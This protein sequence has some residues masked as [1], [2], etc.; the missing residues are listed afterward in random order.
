[1]RDMSHKTKLVFI[2]VGILLILTT[3][4][5]LN[6]FDIKYPNQENSANLKRNANLE[7]IDDILLTKI[8]RRLNISTFGLVSIFDKLQVKNN[9][10]NPITSFYIGIPIVHSKDLIYCKATGYDNNILLTE[11]SNIIMN[12]FELLVIYFDTPLLPQQSKNI[13]FYQV[14]K[15]LLNYKIDQGVQSISFVGHLY[16]TLPYEANGRIE[17]IVWLSASSNPTSYGWGVIAPDKSIVYTFEGLI[18]PFL[19]TMKENKEITIEFNDASSTKLEAIE[20]SREILFS[21]WGIIKI[22][23]DFL[24]QN[25]G[26]IDITQVS[27][28][29]P[30]LVKSVYVSDDLGEILGIT[31]NSEILPE[32]KSFSINL[33]KNRVKLT[34]ESKFKFS[35][36]YYLPFENRTSFNWF[37]ESIHIDDLTSKFAFLGRNQVIKLIVE[38]SNTIDWISEFPD[39][40]EKFQ[41]LTILSYYSDF[42]SPMDNIYIQFTF[43]VDLFSV[44]L[45]PIIFMLLITIISSFFVM[46]I[47][48]RKEKPGI[49][50]YKG[51]SIPFNEI[52]EF[53]SL[54]EEKNAL[55]LEIRKAE[56]EAKRK[57][58]AKKN[59][60]SILNK[61]TS[62]I[63][64]INREINPFKKI[65]MESGETF[66]LVIKKLNDLEVERISIKDALNLL[67][68]RYKRGKL[69]SRASYLK[70]SNDYLKRLKKIDRNMDKNIQ[71]LRSFLF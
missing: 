50:E 56:T 68:Q 36:Q 37:Q 41:G 3:V 35:I 52:R 25:V 66:S 10:N 62:K 21:P 15:D 43:T 16:P 58:I 65:L 29:I 24:I 34:P 67:E 55:V 42:I 71:Q 26:L 20:L 23:E 59:Y 27:L 45:R 11:R 5:P 70:L 48:T 60:K 30:G 47:K 69:P 31:F 8:D 32:Y 6:S 46:F 64:E 17:T 1:M 61:N 28:Q 51:F 39:A 19:E 44:F 40:I 18:E 4:F 38:G 14:Y 33:L 54:F 53:C 57:K 2:L 9:N 22:K 63:E 7:E 13:R 49:S 12:E